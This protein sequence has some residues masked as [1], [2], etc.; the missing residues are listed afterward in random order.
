MYINWLHMARAGLLATEFYTPPTATAEGQWRQAHM[1]ARFGILTTLLR[2]GQGFVNLTLCVA[3]LRAYACCASRASPTQRQRQGGGLHRPHQDSIVR[4]ALCCFA[5]SAYR[6]AQRRCSRDPRVPAGHSCVPALDPRLSHTF[7]CNERTYR[8]AQGDRRRC[9][10][11][12]ALQGCVRWRHW[13]R[14]AHTVVCTEATNV[15]AKWLELRDIVV[16]HRQPRK[17]FVQ[18]PRWAT[19]RRACESPRDRQ[20]VL[21]LKPDG[22][23]VDLQEYPASVAGLAQSM[24][25][26]FEVRP[27]RRPVCTPERPC[28]FWPQGNPFFA[29]WQKHALATAL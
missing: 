7:C 25:D 29:Q 18:V 24:V 22:S 28:I 20:A 5:I 12:E 16:A 4:V 17:I 14:L 6:A 9:G 10:R 15:P 8:G 13:R 21:R 1:Q 11:D 27:S 3:S 26:R 23:D 2:A 19:A